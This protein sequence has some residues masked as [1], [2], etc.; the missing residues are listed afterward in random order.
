ML[1]AHRVLTLTA[2]IAAAS[3]IASGYYN[4]TFFPNGAG[5]YNSA[6]TAKIDLGQVFNNT[7]PFFISDQG[8]N[9]MVPGDTFPAL[10][11]QIRAAGAVWNGVATSNARLS[12][13]G[14]ET[15]GLV[16]QNAP[17]IDVVFTDD[18]PPG[19]LAQT[20]ISLPQ[21]LSFVSKGA[22]FVP[23]QRATVELRK[24]L[25][26]YQ[27]ASYYDSFFLTIVHE[28]GHALGL[29]HT[30]T[31]GVM[32]TD[33]T[34]AT[35]KAAPLSPDDIAGISMLYPAPGYVAGTGGIAG[36]VQIGGAGVN[37][38]SVVA[39]SSNAVAS[40]GLPLN[41]G[42]AISTLTNP[43]GTFNMGGSIM[44]T[45]IPCLPPRRVKPIRTILFR[46]RIWQGISFWR[47]PAWTPSFSGTPGIGPRPR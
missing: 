45:H 44:C 20:R 24:D 21:D 42:V 30:L 13:G 10:I 15:M 40:N 34:R 3:S 1:R 33:V 26:V 22:G 31:S 29:Q 18:I 46:L 36:T 17:G 11:N 5:A 19:L 14:M 32:S 43:D 37:L 39:L 2:V 47:T 9:P 7:I 25:T 12:F 6:V 41:Y 27:Q 38:A 23:I 28:F 16:S 35:T 8:P 4:Y